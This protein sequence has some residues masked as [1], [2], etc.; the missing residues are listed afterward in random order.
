MSHGSQ[1]PYAVLS[2]S[3]TASDDE[4]KKAYKRLAVQH[5]PDKNQGSAESTQMFQRISAAYALLCNKERKERYDTTGSVDED[6]MEGP[7]MD[8]L[9]QMFFSQFG[10]GEGFM[11]GGA[12]TFFDFGG[13]GFG[14]SYTDPFME[15]FEGGD[16]FSDDY[17]SM[18]EYGMFMEE[19]MEVVPAL[20]CSHF[21]DIE[22]QAP[23]TETMKGKRPKRPQETFK[24][25]LCKTVMKSPE[26]A[27]NHFMNAHSVL[28]EKFC[29]VID[30]DGME[31]DIVELFED[32]ARKVKLGKV[33]EKMGK[34]K[35]AKKK[36]KS[37]NRKKKA[38]G[39]TVAVTEKSPSNE[40]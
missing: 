7:D 37:R 25:T 6:D 27:E 24:C 40:Q 12:P 5:H 1:C 20:F 30:R 14:Q 3:R 28:L 29:N 35:P 4:I 16:E 10:G 9:M 31:S 17:D 11:F 19:F 33:T 32:F 8:D 2:V 38:T 34:N 13:S 21:I 36:S 15:F 23:A 18:D 22:E 26:A 39:P